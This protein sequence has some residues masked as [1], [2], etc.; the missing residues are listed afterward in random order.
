MY[1]AIQDLATQDPAAEELAV[2]ISSRGLPNLSRLRQRLVPAHH[3]GYAEAWQSRQRRSRRA[4]LLG[5]VWLS[6]RLAVAY[7]VEGADR[8][9]T[10]GSSSCW[11]ALAC[12]DLPAESPQEVATPPR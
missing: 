11:F 7:E 2:H 1:L 8:S 6:R 5:A 4:C 10:V 3:H 12:L 9:A